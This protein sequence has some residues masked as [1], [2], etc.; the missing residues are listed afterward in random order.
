MAGIDLVPIPH[1][2]FLI[3]RLAGRAKLHVM[4]PYLV[5]QSPGE[6]RGSFILRKVFEAVRAGYR[7]GEAKHVRGPPRAH[8]AVVSPRGSCS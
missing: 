4:T 1:R 2:P 5:S 3:Y 8:T 6:S 7:R